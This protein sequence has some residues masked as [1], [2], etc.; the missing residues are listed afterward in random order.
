LAP[1][2]AKLGK[3]LKRLEEPSPIYNTGIETKKAN[4]P[5]FMDL[6]G[7]QFKHG[8]EKY[9]LDGQND[10]EFTDLVCEMAPGKTGCDWILQTMLKYLGRF[11]NFQREKDLLKIATYC[12]IIWLKKGFH[13]QERHDEDTKQKG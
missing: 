3:I 9:L 12:Y 13:L 1:I 6:I 2:P 11:L 7:N 4:F 8:G 5:A 10:K